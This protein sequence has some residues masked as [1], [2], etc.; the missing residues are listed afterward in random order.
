MDCVMLREGRFRSVMCEPPCTTF[1][2]AAHPCVR[3]YDEPCGFDRTDE[4]T[5]LGNML[6]FRCFAIMLCAYHYDRPNLLEQPFLSK[7]AWLS[8]WA[9]LRSIGFE[10]SVVVSCEFGNVHKEP[11]QLLSWGLDS[12][13][14]TRC[15]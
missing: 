12:E 2:P 14:L 5:W 3:S 13:A 4:K 7:M 15:M 10:V 9:F 11:F 8:I 1:S 6:A